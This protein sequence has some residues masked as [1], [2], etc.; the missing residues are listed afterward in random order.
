[1]AKKV[2]YAKLGLKVNT[3]V[4]TFTFKDNEI[5]VLKYLPINDKY[6]L[7]YIALQRAEEDGVYNELKLDMYF[8]LYLV[9][10]YTNLTFT[11]KQREDEQKIYDCLASN[12][13]FDLFLN[14]IEESEYTELFE[15]MT[16]IKVEKMKYSNSAGAVLQKVIS[17]LPTNAEAAASLINS[18][19][20]ENYR[21]IV[22]LAQA[23]GQNNNNRN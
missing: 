20:P 19:D 7:I 13:F 10:M 23:T 15:M 18:F 21:T 9:Y 3:D 16:A 11:D 2:S 5:E 6:D 8:H 1:M 14:A 4:N 17:D 12:G 22:E